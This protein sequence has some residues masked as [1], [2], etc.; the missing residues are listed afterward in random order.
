MMIMTSFRGFLLDL[1]DHVLAQ[2]MCGIVAFI[3]FLYFFIVHF[4]PMLTILLTMAHSQ[5]VCAT[6]VF[7]KGQIVA[8]TEAAEYLG[9]LYNGF[10]SFAERWSCVAV[11]PWPTFSI[12][13]ASVT[14]HQ[15]LASCSE[16]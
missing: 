14:S 16:F 7:V 11:P 4:R 6:L 1:V 5:F 10:L 2:K 9:S 13:V 8:R 12:A 15:V 3:A